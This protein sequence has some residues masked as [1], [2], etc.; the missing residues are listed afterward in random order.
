MIRYNKSK[1]M[2]LAHH[3]RKHEGFTMSQALTLAWSKARRDKFYM[4]I[5]VLKPQRVS[6]PTV[7][8]QY[9]IDSYY[10][11]GAYSGD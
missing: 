11:N 5:E 8:S 7:M 2:R 6:S 3:L 10:A 9:Q 4:V 1:I